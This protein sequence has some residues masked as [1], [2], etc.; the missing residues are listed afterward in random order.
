[1]TVF[2][3]ES[4]ESFNRFVEKQI[5]ESFAK[6]GLLKHLGTKHDYVSKISLDYIR[7]VY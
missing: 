6:A 1:M 2:T 4:F 3:N 5:I 7:Y